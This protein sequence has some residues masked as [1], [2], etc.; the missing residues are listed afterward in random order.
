M[1]ECPHESLH[2]MHDALIEKMVSEPPGNRS[3]RRSRN[4]FAD[5]LHAAFLMCALFCSMAAL[6][7]AVA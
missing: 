5:M 4:V 7:D 6:L 2:E 3:E 1:T